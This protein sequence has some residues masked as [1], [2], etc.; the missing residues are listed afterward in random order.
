MGDRKAILIDA[1]K[2]ATPHNMYDTDVAWVEH[3]QRLPVSIFCAKLNRDRPE[4]LKSRLELRY[5]PEDF[6]RHFWG[7]R[8]TFINAWRRWSIAGRETIGGMLCA[9]RPCQP[10][11]NIQNGRISTIWLAPGRKHPLTCSIWRQAGLL[12]T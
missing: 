6:V 4:H 12:V 5:P 10:R 3:R 7:T 8:A 11:R 2:L 1:T 9:P